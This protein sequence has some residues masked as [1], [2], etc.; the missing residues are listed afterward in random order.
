LRGSPIYLGAYLVSEDECGSE[1][2]ERD[3]HS[4]G[5]HDDDDDDSGYHDGTRA[6]PPSRFVQSLRDVSQ[7][8]ASPL[9][10]VYGFV[11]ANN[12]D[13]SSRQLLHI[14]QLSK[15]HAQDI[16]EEVEFWTSPRLQDEEQSLR[17]QLLED[18]GWFWGGAGNEN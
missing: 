14:P 17:Q 5:G 15:E 7:A 10:A 4:G 9:T 2:S 1:T 12:D 11:E 16:Q 3:E 13:G 8:R 18:K 6:Q